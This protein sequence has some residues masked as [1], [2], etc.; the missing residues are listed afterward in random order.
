[1]Q[2]DAFQFDLW[3]DPSVI[4]PAAVAASLNGTLA[5][6]LSVVANSSQPGLLKVAVYGAFPVSGDGVYVDLRFRV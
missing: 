2:I 3:F 1:M 6:S 5:D 4:S